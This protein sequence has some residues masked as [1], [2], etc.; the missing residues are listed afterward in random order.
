MEF[1]KKWDYAKP[2]DLAVFAKKEVKMKDGNSFTAYDGLCKKLDMKLQLTKS[3][4]G[5]FLI[6]K[7]FPKLDKSGDAPT[8]TVNEEDLFL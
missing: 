2:E 1:E 3:K 5:K 4:D 6:L 7:G 8:E